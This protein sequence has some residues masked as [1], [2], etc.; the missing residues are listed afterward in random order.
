MASADVLTLPSCSS[1]AALPGNTVPQ[2]RVSQQSSNR[3]SS[4]G[5]SALNGTQ[6]GN[7]KNY[8]TMFVRNTVALAVIHRLHKWCCQLF[9]VVL[10][11][12]VGEMQNS[13]SETLADVRRSI[14]NSSQRRCKTITDLEMQLLRHLTCPETALRP[15]RVQSSRPMRKRHHLSRPPSPQL[16]DIYE[17][18]RE[19]CESPIAAH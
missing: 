8:D 12:C 15:L 11:L 3:R 17:D 9:C 16:F 7:R 2:R 1:L 6:N 18:E 19:T 4:A 10:F 5:K 13:K 14:V